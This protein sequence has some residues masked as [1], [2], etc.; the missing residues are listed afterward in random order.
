MIQDKTHRTES[1]L[2]VD[3]EF[4]CMACGIMLPFDAVIVY[5]MDYCPECK[6]DRVKE[7]LRSVYGTLSSAEAAATFEVPDQE[8]A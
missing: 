7:E 4:C 3:D 6:L 2:E 1:V 8:G 5:G